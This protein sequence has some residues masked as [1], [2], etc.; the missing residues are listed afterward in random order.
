[1]VK[2]LYPRPRELP[3]RVDVALPRIPR[4]PHE[5]EK[6]KDV[7]VNWSHHQVVRTPKNHKKKISIQ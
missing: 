4:P 3:P 2:S 5:Q 6:S 7:Y 1:M